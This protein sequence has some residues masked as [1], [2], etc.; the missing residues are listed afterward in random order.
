[1]KILNTHQYFIMLFVVF[2]SLCIVL[3]IENFVFLN[4]IP[5]FQTTNKTLINIVK[6]FIISIIS[7]LEN[8]FSR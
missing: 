6:N 5:K 8:V 1:M 2:F 3:N 4:Q 7:K